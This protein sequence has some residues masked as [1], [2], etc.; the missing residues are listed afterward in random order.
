M[1]SFEK[2]VR[3][4]IANELGKVTKNNFPAIYEAI[5]TQQG[6]ERVELMII[7]YMINN[8]FT[9]SACIPPIETILTGE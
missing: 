9:A 4:S 3:D 5:Q 6:Y 8:G 1:E 2:K 7:Q